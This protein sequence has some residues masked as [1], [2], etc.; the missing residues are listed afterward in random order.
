VLE[1]GHPVK[2]SQQ[3]HL[4]D[5]FG[6]NNLHLFCKKLRVDP[7]TFHALL[8][9]IEDQP[10]FYNNSNIPQA[11]PNVQLAIFL[12]CIGHYG[13]AASP[14]DL[15]QWAGGS[16]GWIEKCTNHVMVAVLALHDK[17]IHL[18]TADEKEDAKAW[19][20]GKTCPEWRDGFC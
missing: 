3:L 16:A 4:L 13:N 11:S 19:V 14:E 1:P 9:M 6:T 2:K 18:P 12:N 15:A 8:A 10:I 17:G 5:D 7:S 20:E